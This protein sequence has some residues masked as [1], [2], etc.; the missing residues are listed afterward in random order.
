MRLISKP[1]AGA[2]SPKEMEVD[3]EDL[4]EIFSLFTSCTDFERAQV[5]DAGSLHHFEK[6]DLGEEYTLTEETREY[7]ID[8]LSAVL[9]FLHS[10]G[11]RLAD[12]AEEIDL[13]SFSTRATLHNASDLSASRSRP[14][15]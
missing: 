11:L 12:G 14:P 10:R 6:V 1:G 2:T 15:R 13:S 3:P 7:A 9:A 8:A 5:Y 4:K